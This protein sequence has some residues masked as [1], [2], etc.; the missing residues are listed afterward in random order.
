MLKTFAM[1]IP[2]SQKTYICLYIKQGFGLIKGKSNF[3]VHF[4]IEKWPKFDSPDPCLVYTYTSFLTIRNIDFKLLRF[5][6]HLIV[7]SRI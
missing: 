3:V 6:L 5:S 1:D 7:E 2:D 4:L